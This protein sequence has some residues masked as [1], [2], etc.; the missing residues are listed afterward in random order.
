MAGA[1]GSNFQR[2]N[3]NSHTAWEDWAKPLRVLVRLLAQGVAIFEKLKESRVGSCDADYLRRYLNPFA[4]VKIFC[5]PENFIH[6]DHW[7]WQRII[8]RQF[9][10]GVHWSCFLYSSEPEIFSLA[11]KAEQRT[12]RLLEANSS[13]LLYRQSSV[14]HSLSETGLFFL[15]SWTIA[16]SRFIYTISIR[17]GCGS[18]GRKYSPR[19]SAVYTT[20]PVTWKMIKKKRSNTGC[21]WET[22]LIPNGTFVREIR[23]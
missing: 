17:I 7:C 2:T 22:K 18:I 23:D 9:D 15:K 12:R 16:W 1:S 4:M 11:C 20:Q 3:T 19:N 13:I 14:P 10:D 6:S 5:F 21:A 8:V